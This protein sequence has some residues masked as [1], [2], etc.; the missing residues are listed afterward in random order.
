MHQFSSASSFVMSAAF[1]RIVESTIAINTIQADLPNKSGI[2]N[3]LQ[4]VEDKFL[5]GFD[6]WGDYLFG[7]FMIVVG[8][9]QF[10]IIYLSSSP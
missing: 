9:L 6:P 1:E 4:N 8:K 10:C 3:G 2:I 7:S 5:S